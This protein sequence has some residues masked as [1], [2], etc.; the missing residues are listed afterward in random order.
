MKK[1]LLLLGTLLLS[2]PL[3]AN[4]TP[5]FYWDNQDHFVEAKNCH[6]TPVD[7]N[8]FRISKYFG[9]GTSST[10]NLR[11]VNG[12]RTS[13][14]QNGSLVK[15]ISGKK[16]KDYEKIEVVGLNTL[17]DSVARWSSK[18]LDRGY[19]YNRSMNPF[20]DYALRLDQ[21][22][23]NVSLG[24]VKEKVSGLF[25][26]IAVEDSYFKL[27]CPEFAK[28]RE[29][30]MFRVYDETVQ[31]APIAYAGVY[32]DET[33]IFRSFQTFSK[34]EAHRLVNHI[35]NEDR[36]EEE[37]NG[38]IQF[39]ES[40][41]TDDASNDDSDVISADDNEL[42]ATATDED[43]NDDNSDENISD[44]QDAVVEGPL[45]YRVCIAS[46]KLNI[47]N[48]RLD[49]VVYSARKGEKVKIFQGWGNNSQNRT[50]NGVNYKFIKIQLSGREASD[51]TIGW[52]AQRYIKIK[53][54]CKYLSNSGSGATSGDNTSEGSVEISGLN[55]SKCCEFPTVKKVTHRFNSGMRRF[56]A[57]RSGGA[58]LHAA[59]DLYR[60][61]NEPILSVAPGK[62]IRN[63]Y[64]FYQGTYALEVRHSGGFVVRYGEITGKSASGTSAGRSVKMGQ[65][66]GYMGKVNSN[67]CRPMLHF[68]LYSGSKS[69]SLSRGGTRY[70]RRSDLLDP[71]EYLLQWE[72]RNF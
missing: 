68:E 53:S 26:K 25:F 63:K 15:F 3:M 31:D 22:A 8:K 9:K 51:Q 42:D 59:C 69:G 61:K 13:F 34:A 57:G 4:E 28:D 47:R 14:L 30:I 20:D 54:Q 43:N 16:L 70:R 60:Y 32:W 52:A 50:I 41:L 24:K 6:I 7:S 10:E 48:E 17:S 45:D 58:R 44:N 2:A 23:P 11:N 65:Q 19:L 64:Y 39:G 71:T 62:I 67:C 37:L 21:K 29:Y 40:S 27:N 36:L 5:I 38:S 56:G 33:A 1:T 35:L 46:K 49:K 66:I 18:R 55:D 72:S 12:V